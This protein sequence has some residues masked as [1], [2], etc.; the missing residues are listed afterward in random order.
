MKCDVLV[1]GGGGAGLAAAV[2]AARAGA[3]TILVERH[4]VLGGMATVALVHSVCGLYF[5]REEP[6][7]VLAHPGFPSEFAERLIRAGAASGPTRMGRVDVLLHSPPGF[8]AVADAVAAE[9]PSLEVR[10]HAEVI[11]ARGAYHVEA[12]DLYSRG[13]HVTV[14]PRVVVDASGDGVLAELLHIPAEQAPANQLQRP[15]F[16]FALHSVDVK[17]LD[18]DG[19]I[20]AACQIA[21]AVR[22]GQL[23]AGCLG[24]HFRASGRGSE[25]YVTVD[26]AADANFQPT[27]SAQLTA[28]E[29]AGRRLAMELT[30][31]LRQEH[32]GFAE[33]QIAAFPARIGVRESRRIRGLATITSEDVMEGSIPPDPVAL[34]TWPIELRERHTGPRWR[35]PVDNRPTQIPLR[36]LQAA[37]MTNLWIA[38]RCIS[39]DHEAQA[40]LRV[41]G[42]CMATGQAAGAAAALQ[43]QAGICPS[44]EMV[45]SLISP[46]S[47]HVVQHC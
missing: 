34:G 29:Q 3:H 18:D 20:R 8:A 26:L 43:A 23:D 31:F 37:T 33:A 5:L 35:F 16:I 1:I 44:A 24:A 15:A 40:A 39:C 41:I 28:L 10:L 6:D 46:A 2:T 25:V 12:V 32:A 9:C 45:R 30:A 13:A 36:A 38:G 17:A 11:A 14:E 42:T 19:R 27:D 21:A 47:P 7:A 4:G 22:A